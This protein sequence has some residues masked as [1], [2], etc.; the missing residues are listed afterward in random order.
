MF[1]RQAR[2]SQSRVGTMLTIFKIK[3]EIREAMVQ[4]IVCTV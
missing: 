1:H 4:V 2:L 3:V